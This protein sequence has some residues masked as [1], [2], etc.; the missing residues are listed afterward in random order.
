MLPKNLCLAP[1]SF[2]TVDPAMNVSP[3]PALGGSVWQFPNDSIVKVW[4][5]GT[6]EDFRQHMLSNGQHE[7][8]QRCWSEESVGM[9]SQRT[10]L[11]DPG[12]DPTG[13][14]TDILQSGLY[15]VHVLKPENYLRGPM[16]LV[17]K[18]SNLCNL[19]CRSC[20][21][22]D[23][24][25][26]RVEGQRYQQLYSPESNP[27][28]KGNGEIPALND[29]QVEEIVELADNLKRIEFYGGEPLL[30]AQLP[31]LLARLVKKDL[32]KNINI[33]ISTNIT[34][35]I[36]TDLIETL[37]HF[38]HFNLNL[39]IDG[40]SKRF[41]YLRHPGRWDQV[42]NNINWFV[43]LRDTG[44]INMSLLPVIT[45]TNMNVFYL[46]ELIQQLHTHWQ[47]QPFLIKA[48]YPEHFDVA[49]IPQGA[50]NEIAQRLRQFAL[51]DLSPIAAALEQPGSAQRWQEFQ[52]WTEF[53]DQSRNEK[54][55]DTFP[56]YAELLRKYDTEFRL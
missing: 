54:F 49:T 30:D 17:I 19:R 51:Q 33:N 45:V 3:C 40:W 47:L 48:W 56:E 37:S 18:V 21:S 23:S 20:N 25:T 12:V 14:N 46:D 26:L 43:D 8:C 50:A 27:M 44:P 10:R 28:L 52:Q 42:Y 16:Q 39:S 55:S 11:W 1:F 31:I 2:I 22:Q 32:A 34:N 9:K 13:T 24:I 36:S 5:S 38:N 53:L 41:E 15:P 4:N 6:L 7:V 29:Q 35:R